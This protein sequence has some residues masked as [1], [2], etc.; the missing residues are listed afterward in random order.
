MGSAHGTFRRR[1]WRGPPRLQ[2]YTEPSAGTGKRGL[3]GRGCR[4]LPMAATRGRQRA[5]FF[6]HFQAEGIAGIRN[7]NLEGGV[8][9]SFSMAARRGR[10]RAVRHAAGSEQNAVVQR[11][12]PAIGPVYYFFQT[13]RS[14]GIISPAWGLMPIG[15][16]CDPWHWAGHRVVFHVGGLEKSVGRLGGQLESLARA[17]FHNPL[18]NGSLN[19]NQ[20]AGLKAS[21]YRPAMGAQAPGPFPQLSFER[22]VRRES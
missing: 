20:G 10:Q 9:R 11:G 8:Q 13:K 12:S 15:Q 6:I 7:K 17:L 3:E 22:I 18:L 1:G 16:L 14:T 4:A 21:A 2:P 5:R 19:G